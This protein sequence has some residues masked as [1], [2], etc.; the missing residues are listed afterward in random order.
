MMITRKKFITGALQMGIALSLGDLL[1]CK[2]GGEKKE[3]T[4]LRLKN[5]DNPSVLEKKHVP[6]IES[7]KSIKKGEELEVRVKVGYATEHPSTPHHWIRWIKLQAN[8][9]PVGI[10]EFKTGG[11]KPVALFKVKLEESA[12]LEAIA[13]CNLHGTWIGEPFSVTVA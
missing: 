2:K 7:E 8:G 12:T 5:K 9:K 13:D 4:L 11:E 10:R 6:G 1:L 3:G